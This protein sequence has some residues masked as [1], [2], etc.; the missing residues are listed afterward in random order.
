MVR[1]FK[2]ERGDIGTMAWIESHQTLVKHPKTL[3]LARRLQISIPTVIGHLHMLWWWA[4]EYAQDGDLTKCD[5]EDIAIAM[6]WQGDAQEL[7]NALVDVGFLDQMYES[8]SIHD[9]YEYAGRLIE[10]RAEDA[11]RKRKERERKRSSN[12]KQDVQEMSDGRPD[13]VTG[14]S[15]VT[16][17]KPIPKPIPNIKDKK[18]I[19]ALIDTTKN[20]YGEFVS[21]T[22]DEYQKLV[23]ANGKE[24]TDRCVEV[25][26]NY[27]GASGKRYKSDY[28]A[29]LNWV[30]GRVTEERSKSNGKPRRAFSGDDFD[31]N[32]LSL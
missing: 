25:L 18:H 31:Y 19:R 16:V 1:K 6:D 14:M 8:L 26:D 4:L 32:S 12:K 13:D 20:K 29:I 23:E 21:L 11:E 24:F 17:P 27:K 10:R 15:C 5:V 9:W 7:I 22:D 3:K 30:V 28:R 2:Q